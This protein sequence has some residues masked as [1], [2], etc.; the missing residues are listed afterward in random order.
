MDPPVTYVPLDGAVPLVAPFP[1]YVIVLVFPTQTAVKAESPSPTVKVPPP[2]Y[3][4]PLFSQPLNVY[5]VLVNVGVGKTS[6]S[7]IYLFVIEA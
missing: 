4:T 3:V 7:P 6:R 5:P 1:L 2:G